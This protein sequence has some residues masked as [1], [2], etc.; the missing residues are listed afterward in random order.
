MTA[1]KDRTGFIFVSNMKK[2]LIAFAVLFLGCSTVADKAEL[3]QPK[4]KEILE[5]KSEVRCFYR[6]ETN[7]GVCIFMILKEE[8]KNGLFDISLEQIYKFCN[9]GAF[10]ASKLIEDDEKV[11]PHHFFA[12]S[13]EKATGQSIFLG[14]G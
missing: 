1:N 12:C 6:Q 7:R 9:D 11:G 14:M 3:K 2:F 4:T 13:E 10:Y 8:D 5:D